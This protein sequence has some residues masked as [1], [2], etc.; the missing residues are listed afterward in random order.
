MY[1]VEY[2]SKPDVIRPMQPALSN[3]VASLNTHDM[4]PFASFIQGLDFKD[5]I[6]MELLIEEE[7]QK[8]QGVRRA[9][10]RAASNRS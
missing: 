5:R 9:I 6:R 2:E 1:I 10:R 7:A 8:E 4:P 3:S